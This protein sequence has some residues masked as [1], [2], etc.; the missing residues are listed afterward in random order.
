MN[1]E[2]AAGNTIDLRAELRPGINTLYVWHNPN[3]CGSSL[4]ALGLWFSGNAAPELA[5]SPGNPC[6]GYGGVLNSAINGDSVIG[7]NK[8]SAE[9]NGWTVSVLSYT[10][11]QSGDV[12]RPE[13]VG[14]DGATDLR[15]TIVLEVTSNDPD[16]DGV[17]G[18]IDNCPTIANPSQA[19]CDNDG[20]GDACETNTSDCNSNGTLDS[21]DLTSGTS[22]DADANGIPDECQPDC[23]LNG[24]PDEFEIASGLVS[25]LNS[26][27]TPDD[28][29]GA[30]MIRLASSN[31]GAPSGAAARVWNVAE[32]LP[33]ETNVTI[34]VDLRGDL[35]GAT[36]WA[37]VVLNDG[38]P[39][40]FFQSN[41]SIC[42]ETPDHAEI[43]LTRDEWNALVGAEGLLSVRVECPPT[44][45]GS[46][47]KDQGLTLLTLS[48]V[49][50][51]P[52]G[53][54]NGNLRLDVAETHDGTTPDCNGN[55]RPDSCDIDAGTAADCNANGVPDGCELAATPAL[56]CNGNGVIDSCDLATAGAAI[57]C[58]L[59]GRI[60]SCQVT[61][62]P[63]TD[64]NGNLRPD[65]C[66]IATGT[67][68]DIDQN[69]T[70]DECQTV[71]VPGQYSG[72]QA[73][74][75]AAPANEMRIISV[76]AGT[77]A[78][79]IAFN[80]KPVIVRGAGA[81]STVL[82]GNGGQQLSVV[83]FT[84]G[85]PAIAALE[86]VTVRGG[87]TGS[88]IP[89]SPTVIVG[90]G[91]FGLDSAASIRDCV[92]EQNAGGFGGGGYFLRCSGEVRGTTFRNNN[93]S[94]DGGGFQSNLGTQRLT[95]VV[96]EGNVCNSRGGGMH[97]VQGNPAL[98][99]VTVRNNYSN[100]LIGGVS[101][102]ALGSATATAMLDDCTV[103]GNNALVT[104]GGIGISAPTSG[105]PTITLRGTEACDNAPRPN[106]SGL[107]ADLGGNVICDCAGDL[108]FDGVVNGA[109]LGIL[110][111]AWG[112]CG[113]S[114]ASDLNR[115][116]VVN[117][118]DLGAMLSEWGSC[119]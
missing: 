42:P 65:A 102:F 96:I 37:D 3:G 24:T 55:K 114:C 1:G 4:F 93:A 83:R 51:T 28:C 91:I 60:D 11:G 5:V 23:N 118:A 108:T 64:C 62:T 16:D 35:N 13:S 31:L 77:Y 97:L 52:A 71:A 59:N 50:V 75:D 106:V 94:A 36:E 89:G 63:G 110:L 99:R 90:G 19:D 82:E 20:Q 107:W 15:A 68:G 74:I 9:I 33:A 100:N 47:C 56:D 21:C 26:D 46:E 76:A 10:V 48:Y 80:G 88:P 29:Q 6:T 18:P 40:R 2:T 104:Q 30:R 111:S 53:D 116:G 95:D 45:D 115:D 84:G 41:G 44:V 34:T 112:T 8:V 43:S 22:P 32:L 101:W 38:K 54:C 14:S 109:D 67:S 57:D 86:R 17:P 105:A 39:R 113:G 61:E 70:P 117:G 72:I 98:A 66:D 49:G 73:A 27:G 79:P 119:E 78:G 103:T 7:S 69:A 87:T 25:D 92:V 81:A 85:E 12:V 58:D